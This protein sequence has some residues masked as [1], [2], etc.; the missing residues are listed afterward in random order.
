MKKI[1]FILL[2]TM[3]GCM[4]LYA[5]GDVNIVPFNYDAHGQTAINMF[6]NR[7]R[8]KRKAPAAL[9]NTTKPQKTVVYAAVQQH[10]QTHSKRPESL[11]GFIMYQT[12]RLSVK[13]PDI[14]E[15]SPQMSLKGMHGTK[16][17]WLLVDPNQRQKGCGKLLMN[18]AESMAL[19]KKSDIVYLNSLASALGFYTKIGYQ[20]PRIPNENWHF[21]IKPLTNKGNNLVSAIETH[22]AKHNETDSCQE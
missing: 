1:I 5:M 20:K 15:F 22:G 14:P 3:P 4:Q 13:S 6:L 10:R 16:I 7:F 18:H 19:E 12:K 8:W 11:L 2:M 17:E 21:M 9:T